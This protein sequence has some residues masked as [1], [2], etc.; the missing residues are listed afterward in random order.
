[1]N[2]LASFRATFGLALAIAL[3]ACGA[4]PAA[5]PDTVKAA[6]IETVSAA[7][8]GKIRQFVGR[9]EAAQTVDIAFQVGGRLARFPVE[10]GA[11]IA[12]GDLIAQLE[13]QDFQ[14][15]L[16]EAEVRLEQTAADLRRQQELVERNAAPRTALENARTAHDLAVVARDRARQNLD[17]ATLRA[18][19]DGFVSRKFLDNFTSVAPGAPI[20]RLQDSGELRVAI[21]VPEDL[22]AT[23][24]ENDV[25]VRAVFPF[26]PDRS[27]NL[28][29]R[30][31]VAEPDQTS[32]TY[33]VLLALPDDIPANILPG[34]TANVTALVNSP[35]DFADS[36]GAVRV[37]IGAL[38]DTPE[39]G[40]AV[41]V[42][43]GGDGAVSRRDVET[44][45]L[46]NEGVIVTAGL[47][48]GEQ[49]VTAGVASLREGMRVRPLEN[50]AD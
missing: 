50:G 43:D 38:A 14:R 34:M 13:L 30:E 19:F 2:R 37:P 16:R 27:F 25:F 15:A 26:L 11:E 8:S 36:A 32:Q 5:E 6:R 20:A 48:P 47:S 33:R 40:Y 41:W 35:T 23:V 42:Y 4:E 9:V 17:Y 21:N 28:E 12:E 29:Y 45:R 18:P 31:L 49:V 3:A 22:I 24:S 44:S 39:G 10:E 7:S 46:D 1:M